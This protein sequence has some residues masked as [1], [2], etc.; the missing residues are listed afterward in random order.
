MRVTFF[1][2]LGGEWDLMNHLKIGGDAIC[3]CPGPPRRPHS[4]H[5]PDPNC[6]CVADELL[7]SDGNRRLEMKTY[8][9]GV[10]EWVII[11]NKSP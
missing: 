4:H 2:I 1:V 5:H 7:K 10:N 3:L 6:S 9:R 8:F 11:S